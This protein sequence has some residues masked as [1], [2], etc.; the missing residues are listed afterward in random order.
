MLS[1]TSL[2]HLS[3]LPSDGFSVGFGSV[4]GSAVGAGVADDVSSFLYYT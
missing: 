4:V 1:G 3:A 2:N